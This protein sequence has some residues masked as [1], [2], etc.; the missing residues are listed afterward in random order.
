MQGIYKRNI[1]EKTKATINSI[2]MCSMHKMLRANIIF[3]SK[4]LNR[5]LTQNPEFHKTNDKLIISFGLYSFNTIYIYMYIILKN[6][7]YTFSYIYI[8]IYIYIKYIY[9]IKKYQVYF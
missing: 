2:R 3:K 7:L 8:Y 5:I 1:Y 9:I 4:K 6:I